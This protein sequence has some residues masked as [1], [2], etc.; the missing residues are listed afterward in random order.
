MVASLIPPMAPKHQRQRQHQQQQHNQQKDFCVFLLL[1][2]HIFLT[3]FCYL[4]N[5]S[6]FSPYN[7]LHWCCRIICLSKCSFNIQQESLTLK[8][9][10]DFLYFF[11]AKIHL[12]KFQLFVFLLIDKIHLLKFQTVIVQI[13]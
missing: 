9:Y 12:F 10:F 6:L 13:A 8:L 1:Q 4:F 2:K 5:F 7:E 11:F 3:A